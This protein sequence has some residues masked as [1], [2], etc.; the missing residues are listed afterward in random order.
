MSNYLHIIGIFPIIVS[1]FCILEFR[2][3]IK[4][5]TEAPLSRHLLLQ[6]LRDYKRPN[7]KIHELINNGDLISLKRGLY[8]AGPNADLP[9]PES[10]LIANN[11]RGPSYVS[12]ESALSYLGFIPERTYEISSVTTKSS[13][14]FR[15]PLGRFDYQK[16]P[17]PYYAFGIQWMQLKPGQYALMASPEKAV[18]DKIVLTPHINLRSIKQTVAFLFD[19]MRMDEELLNSLN[20]DMID[21]WISDSPKKSSLKIL[22]STLNEIC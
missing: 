16:L 9:I 14:K 13:K 2:K 21:S 6:K 5:Y 4:N 11:L 3:L 10:F 12:L 8:V 22:I 1:L 18:C 19:D 7:D 20:V 17:T 15:T